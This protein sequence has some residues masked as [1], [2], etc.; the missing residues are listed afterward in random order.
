MI[1]GIV[2]MMRPVRL[3]GG[4]MWAIVLLL[5]H[6][7][8]G[9]QK[10]RK[11]WFLP[12][13]GRDLGSQVMETGKSTVTRESHIGK[14]RFQLKGWK[15]A[16]ASGQYEHSY[17]CFLLLSSPTKTELLLSEKEARQRGRISFWLCKVFLQDSG[18]SQI[19][20]SVASCFYRHVE[21][22]KKTF[23]KVCTTWSTSLV[24]PCL[25]SL[26]PSLAPEA[27]MEHHEENPKSSDSI[28]S[29][30]KETSCWRFSCYLFPEKSG[31]EERTRHPFFLFLQANFPFSDLF[32]FMHFFWKEH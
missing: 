26:F 11:R 12:T 13:C 30:A 15:S 23:Y 8:W 21:W 9:S 31:L 2:H 3:W 24:G 29:G 4:G 28:P 6:H 25:L 1:C 19:T 22:R 14:E 20:L 18:F 16:H 32:I 17:F 10:E 7:G 5:L 27:S